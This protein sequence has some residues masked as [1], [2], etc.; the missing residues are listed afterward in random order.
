MMSVSWPEAPE[1]RTADMPQS[2]SHATTSLLFTSSWAVYKLTVTDACRPESHQ[3]WWARGLNTQ[4]QAAHFSPVAPCSP[5][6][7]QAFSY[8]FSITTL[9]SV[10]SVLKFLLLWKPDH[11]PP[12]LPFSFNLTAYFFFSRRTITEN[13]WRHSVQAE[14]M[15]SKGLDLVNMCER[16]ARLSWNVHSALFIRKPTASP[17]GT[18]S[19][20]HPSAEVK[21]KGSSFNEELNLGR[22]KKLPCW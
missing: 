11:S 14:A 17:V 5:E 7:Q 4:G 2:H 12:F 6:K 8:Y 16:V 18:P 9:N 15:A 3:P 20:A 13:N 22:R 10:L 1:L 19:I 21:Q